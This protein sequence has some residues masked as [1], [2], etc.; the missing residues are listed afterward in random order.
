MDRYLPYLPRLQ[1]VSYAALLR[2]LIGI[3]NAYSTRPADLDP[4]AIAAA[5]IS[6]P[7]QMMSPLAGQAGTVR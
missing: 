4:A 2:Q 3:Y 1:L 6:P 7:L 5:F